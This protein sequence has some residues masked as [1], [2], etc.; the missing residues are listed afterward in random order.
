MASPCVLFAPQQEHSP[1]SYVGKRVLVNKATFCV[2]KR[3]EISLLGDD[4]TTLIP[5][6]AASPTSFLQQQ[7][8]QQTCAIPWRH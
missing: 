8:S 2:F 3:K 5:E 4:D 1:L 6:V 7:A